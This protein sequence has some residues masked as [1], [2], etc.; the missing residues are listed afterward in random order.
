MMQRL[1]TAVPRCRRIY[2]FVETGRAALGL[3]IMGSGD[4]D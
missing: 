1:R 2:G 3:S 4:N